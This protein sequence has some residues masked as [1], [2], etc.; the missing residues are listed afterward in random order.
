M[1]IVKKIEKRINSFVTLSG[2]IPESIG[3]TLEELKELIQE[4]PKEI[5]VKKIYYF[6][7]IRLKIIKK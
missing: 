2:K 1:S 5:S 6:N 3:I 7:N 4:K